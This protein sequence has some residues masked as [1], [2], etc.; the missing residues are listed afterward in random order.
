MPHIGN[1]KITL[2]DFHGRIIQTQTQY[3]ISGKQFL[4][5]QLPSSLMPGFYLLHFIQAQQIIR[6]NC[7]CNSMYYFSLLL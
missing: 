4:N 1:A 3:N 6:T 5:M 2:T 7:W